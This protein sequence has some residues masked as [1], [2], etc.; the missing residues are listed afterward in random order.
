MPVVLESIKNPVLGIQETPKSVKSLEDWISAF[1][2]YAAIY[3]EK[4]PSTMA[5]LL[6][7]M[8]VARNLARSNGDWVT[9]DT[10]FRKMQMQQKLGWGVS[11]Q[12][13]YFRALCG[14]MDMNE[15]KKDYVINN[16]G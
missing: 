12:E 5:G 16:Y 1:A 14:V 6:K 11:H 8:E 4:H 3:I 7:Y 9:Y 2:I 15:R 13:L 10:K